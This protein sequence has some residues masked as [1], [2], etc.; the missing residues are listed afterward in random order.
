MFA[1]N[2]VYCMTYTTEILKAS[3][4]YIVKSVTFHHDNNNNKLRKVQKSC[5]LSVVFFFVLFCSTNLNSYF[6]FCI[7]MG[8]TK[9]QKKRFLCA[10]WNTTGSCSLSAWHIVF[11]KR[12]RFSICNAVHIYIHTTYKRKTI[13][14]TLC[15]C[16]SAIRKMN[17]T[18]NVLVLQKKIPKHFFFFQEDDIVEEE[19]FIII[20]IL[21]VCNQAI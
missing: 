17:C 8:N 9:E 21:V 14:V 1:G 5:P 7:H 3:V 2:F 13:E 19:K 4:F 15:R 10:I 11:L 6:H 18:Q 12:R 20:T 16:A